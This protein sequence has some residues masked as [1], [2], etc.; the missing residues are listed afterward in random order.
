[1]DGAGGGG[2]DGGAGDQLPLEGPAAEFE[3]EGTAAKFE[4]EEPTEAQPP[5]LVAGAVG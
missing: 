3:L 4:P 5:L 2:A 1:M